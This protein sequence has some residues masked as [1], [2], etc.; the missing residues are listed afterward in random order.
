MKSMQMPIEK[1][2]LMLVSVGVAVYVGVVALAGLAFFP[3]GL[4]ILA[5]LVLV[6]YVFWCIVRERMARAEDDRYDNNVEN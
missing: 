1:I 4:P 3:W 5:V 2:M 6:G